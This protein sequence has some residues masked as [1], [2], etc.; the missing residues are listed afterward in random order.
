MH[1]V[2]R[3]NA[4]PFDGY[5]GLDFMI[6]Y[7]AT[8]NLRNRSLELHT[9]EGEKMIDN[10]NSNLLN[11]ED[12]LISSGDIESDLDA[13]LNGNVTDA[14]V[15]AIQDSIG[16]ACHPTSNVTSVTMNQ[17]LPNRSYENNIYATN[18]NSA[19]T[20]NPLQRPNQ[21]STTEFE[22]IKQGYGSN[23]Q[24]DAYYETQ[25]YEKIENDMSRYAPEFNRTIE[26][27]NRIQD[28]FLQ[29]R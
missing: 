8:I 9:V 11:N 24:F 21:V 3:A 18:N 12:N 7:G 22:Q 19:G 20:Q 15:N 4:G 10:S 23:T 28:G 25:E 14:G 26:N 16:S 2:N 5:L 1:A 17:H 27:R 6:K 13:G 29:P